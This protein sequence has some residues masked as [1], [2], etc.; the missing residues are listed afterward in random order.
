MPFVN[1]PKNQLILIAGVVWCLAGTMVSVVGLPLEA[2]LAPSNVILL[3]LA[4]VIF[5]VFYFLVFSKLVQKH[6]SRIRGRP[7]ERLPFWNFFNA[8]S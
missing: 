7:E 4:A 8:S 2:S 1:R 6:T 3:P 5:V